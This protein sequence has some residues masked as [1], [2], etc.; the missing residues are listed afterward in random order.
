MGEMVEYLIEATP[1]VDPDDFFKMMIISGYAERFEKGDPMVVSGMSGTELYEHVAEACGIRRDDWSDPLVRYDAGEPYWCGYILAYYQWKTGMSFSRIFS[2]LKYGELARLY[3]AGHT[4][5][6]DKAVCMIE[7]IK[8]S[9]EASVTRIQEYRKRLGMS[10]RML[11][12]AAGVNLR[13]LQQYE[14]SDKDINRAS[15]EKVVALSRVLGCR[16]EDILE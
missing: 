5:S 13:T 15:A 8:N 3:K 12:E 4:A 1:E 10:Q 16:P 14:I 6:E 7:D 11:A 9:K 2:F